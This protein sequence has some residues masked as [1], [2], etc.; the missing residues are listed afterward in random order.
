MP[1]HRFKAITRAAEQKTVIKR[2]QLAIPPLKDINVKST[3]TD[4]IEVTKFKEACSK[5]IKDNKDKV[6]N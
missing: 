1:K 2:Q 6:Y 4:C 3:S 5:D